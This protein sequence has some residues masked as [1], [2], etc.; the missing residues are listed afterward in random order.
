MTTPPTRVRTLGLIEKTILGLIAGATAAIGVVDLVLL[1]GRVIHLAGDSTTVVDGISLTDA[2][3]PLVT[4]ASPFVVAANYESLSMTIEGLPATSRGYLIAAMIAG[5]LVS[6]GI[7][8]MIAWLCLRVFVGRPFVRSTTLG[9]GIVAILVIAGGLGSSLFSSVAHAE[10]MK[11]LDLAGE[12]G[13]PVALFT[14]DLAP[15]GWGLALA[16]VA[17]A[18][19]L[20]QRMQ[21]ETEGLV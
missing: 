6:I 21:R 17:A 3:A 13:L 19:E 5:T 9:I 14:V 2:T 1:V 15:L 20:G 16:V 8:T 18:F 11:F 7:A 10:I 12:Q 4:G